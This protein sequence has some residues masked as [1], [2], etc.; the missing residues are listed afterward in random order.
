MITGEPRLGRIKKTSLTS[1]VMESVK[2]YIVDSDL[3]AGCRLPSEKDMVAELGVSRNIL[4]EGLKSLQAIGLIEIRPGIGM[5]VREFDYAGVMDHISFAVSRTRQELN[6]FMHARLVIEVGALEYVMDKVQE[7][8]IARLEGILARYRDG[9]SYEENAEIDQGFHQTLLA[10]SGN[11]ILAEF[12]G[13]LGR[14]FLEV[15]YYRGQGRSTTTSDD[16]TDVI[17]AL[18]DR[19]LSRA[20]KVMRHHVL[21]WEPFLDT[22]PAQLRRNAAAG[23][24]KLLLP[25]NR[26]R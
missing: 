6:H 13:F 24:A 20:Q 19:D 21:S 23:G 11:P 2:R 1:E 7:E 5:Y 10:I 8:D 26:K 3:K 15:L 25:Q 9:I 4:R 14:F 18:R 12:G 17:Q 22:E 16:H